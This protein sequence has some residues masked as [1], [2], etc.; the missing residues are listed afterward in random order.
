MPLHS[1]RDHTQHCQ[2]IN[3]GMWG[4]VRG[5]F[6]EVM[7]GLPAM[8]RPQT[9]SPIERKH[10]EDSSE[11]SYYADMKVFCSYLLFY[12]LMCPIY[13]LF[14]IIDLPYFQLS[15]KWLNNLWMDPNIARR[16]MQHDSFCCD[17]F[18]NS[19]RLPTKRL[20]N[21]QHV[22]QAFD[23]DDR[24]TMLHIVKYL[25]NASVPIRCR[26]NHTDRIYG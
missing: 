22:G 10:K 9:D 5:A 1:V 8:L 16:F 23:S 7:R 14:N 20:L 11:H 18:P 15:Q 21:F 4:G 24:P 3:G 25:H 19:S 6:P 2:G 26:G 13:R 12:L 17:L